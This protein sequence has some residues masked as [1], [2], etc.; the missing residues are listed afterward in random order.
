MHRESRF[1]SV[2]TSF[3][4]A[5]LVPAGKDTTDAFMKYHPSVN[6]HGI[7]RS[8]Y[9]GTLAAAVPATAFV[10]TEG[11]GNPPPAAQ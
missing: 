11:D 9:L 7:L 10:D 3:G 4:G 2:V 8:G 1:H 5:N 6:Y